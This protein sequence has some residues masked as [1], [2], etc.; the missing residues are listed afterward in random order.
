MHIIVFPSNL[1]LDRPPHTL[2][3]RLLSHCGLLVFVSPSPVLCL[4]LSP[5]A[6]TSPLEGA[7]ALV[8]QPPGT[9]R[10]TANAAGSQSADTAVE[11]QF[12]ARRAAAWPQAKSRAPASPQSAA[13]VTTIG[14][15]SR[16]RNCSVGLS[17]GSV[18]KLGA[19]DADGER[20][21]IPEDEKREKVGTVEA[22]Q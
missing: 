14:W 3:K 7:P 10:G 22:K 11:D 19:K 12:A 18:G 5:K 20:N 9:P 16:S 1:S 6:V 13:S 15:A 4:T 8:L 21:R 2:C 17:E